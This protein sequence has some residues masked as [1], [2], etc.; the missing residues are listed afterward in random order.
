MYTALKK[1]VTVRRLEHRRGELNV[2]F[3]NR[4][5][6]SRS[7]LCFIPKQRAHLI[8]DFPIVVCLSTQIIETRKNPAIVYC[9]YYLVSIIV[10]F[11][12]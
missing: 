11:N 2:M 8:R 1:H 5:A 9:K 7:K 3:S 6:V 4:K 10:V 12:Y